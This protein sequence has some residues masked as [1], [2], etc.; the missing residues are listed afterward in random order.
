MVYWKKIY[1]E[2]VDEKYNRVMV[3]LISRRTLEVDFR[4]TFLSICGS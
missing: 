1:I 2:Y 4:K 3:H